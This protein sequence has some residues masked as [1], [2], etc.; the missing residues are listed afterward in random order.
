MRLPATRG[1]RLT[2]GACIVVTSG[3]IA[4]VVQASIPDGNG[5]I[6][7]CYAA[8]PA[9]KTSGAP[10]NIIDSAAAEC[11]KGQEAI[12]WNQTGVTGPTGATGATGAASTV[13][14]PTGPTGATGAT[15]A[16]ST[17]VGPTGATGAASTV[18]GP[19]GP[20]G[21]TGA[22]STVAGPGGPTGSTGPTGP[23]GPGGLVFDKDVFGNATTNF[24]GTAD[25]STGVCP[26]GDFIFN[27][28]WVFANSLNQVD[29][30]DIESAGVNAN[31]SGQQFYEVRLFDVS[32][33]LANE[34]LAVSAQGWKPSS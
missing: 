13:P 32:S 26:T 9:T 14:G 28:G 12:T 30:G 33:I 1:A 19:T 10:L 20:T 17:V 7:G 24:G 23:A 31:G 25:A 18:A 4:A 22:A 11:G 8:H 15:G 21:A 5:V 3:V 16:A 27:G 2:I 6:H 34:T 29:Y